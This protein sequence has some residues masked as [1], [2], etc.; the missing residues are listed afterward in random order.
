MRA[1]VHGGGL[2]LFCYGRAG[3]VLLQEQGGPRF[4]PSPAQLF[5]R[6]ACN[7][8][9]THEARATGSDPLEETDPPR[10]DQCVGAGSVQDL[11]SVIKKEIM[12]VTSNLEDAA[13]SK[14]MRATYVFEQKQQ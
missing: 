2:A 4:C 11:W 13:Y 12:P 9:T 6:R 5:C 1:C 8:I 14:C 10:P 7:L 3:I